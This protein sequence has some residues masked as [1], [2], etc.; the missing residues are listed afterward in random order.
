M[1]VISYKQINIKDISISLPIKG[2]DG[3]S[4]GIL[5]NNEPLIIQ[6]PV[7]NFSETETSFNMIDNGQ[8]FSLFDNMTNHFIENIFVNSKKFF[9]GKEF[10]ENRICNSMKKTVETFDNG[11]VMLYASK[12]DTKFFNILNDPTEMPIFPFSGKC[13]L[14]VDTIEFSKKDI[15]V[16]V[17][18]KSIKLSSKKLSKKK[19][20]LDF[21]EELETEIIETEIIEPV[22]EPEIIELETEISN[23]DDL[24]F[25]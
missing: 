16:S 17:Y 23:V 14:V 24:E 15:K 5:Y 6:T 10:S 1:T 9:N 8:F 13:I 20:P 18:I 19:D 4:C 12:T 2:T 7:L 3:Y 11:L 22:Q 21:D 25:F